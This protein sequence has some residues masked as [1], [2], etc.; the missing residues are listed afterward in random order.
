METT[1]GEFL[2]TRRERITPEQAGLPPSLTRRRVP[3]LRREEVALLAGVSPDYYQ[4]L[5]QGRTAKVSDQVLDAVA[6]ALSLSDVESEHLRNLARPR[7]ADAEARATRRPSRAVPDEPLV[8]LLEAMGDAPALL[9][10]A[11]LDIVAANA[12]AEAV[13]GV[14][15]MP[16]PRNAARELFLHPD[17]RARYSNWEAIAAETVAQLR[18]LT[19]RRPDDA[20]LAA[21]VGELAIRSEPFRQLWATGDV[22]E[23][24]LGVV[25]IVHPVVGT[26]EFD[27]HVLTVPA[28]PDRSLLTYLPQPG[29]P[30]AEALGMLLSWVADRPDAAGQEVPAAARESDGDASSATA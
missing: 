9:L 7:R 12:A 3:G 8:R 16:Q 6:Q 14:S 25:R 18:L 13:F 23:K 29:S 5:E 27:Y 24:R 30:T 2:R 21:L 20:K 26:L 17:A 1:I 15:G 11:R 4:R 22:R 28:R 19:G 10:D